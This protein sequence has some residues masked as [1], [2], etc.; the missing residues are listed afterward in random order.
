[1]AETSTRTRTRTS[2]I[3]ERLRARRNEPRR[4][5][6]FLSL[7]PPE[8]FSFFDRTRTRTRPRTRNFSLPA[9]GSIVGVPQSNK[10]ALM[11]LKPRV[12]RI[13]PSSGHWTSRT[14]LNLGPFNPGLRSYRPFRGRAFG[15]REP[16]QHLPEISGLRRYFPTTGKRRSNQGEQQN[17]NDQ[18]E[19]EKQPARMNADQPSRG[20]DRFPWK[21]SGIIFIQ[22]ER[23]HTSA[24]PGGRVKGPLAL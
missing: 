10:L 17:E 22:I 12:S 7:G 6:G 11:G 16:A 1:M 5:R 15:P 21:H 23:F 9:K 18:P 8:S 3:E 24:C 13:A 14:F 20:D 2:T 19:C 4:G